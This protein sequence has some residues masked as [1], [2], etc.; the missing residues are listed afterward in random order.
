MKGYGY[1]ILFTLLAATLTASSAFSQEK[2]KGKEWR[3]EKKTQVGEAS[4]QFEELGSSQVK[5]KHTEKEKQQKERKQEKQAVLV[6][7][8]HLSSSSLGR[9]AG[10]LPPGLKTTDKST[11]VT[12]RLDWKNNFKKRDISHPDWNKGQT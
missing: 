10:E 3:E 4:K 8:T 7:E 12:S 1:G 11:V 6:K 9:T 5:G 2:G